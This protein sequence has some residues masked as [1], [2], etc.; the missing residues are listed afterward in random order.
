VRKVKTYTEEYVLINGIY[1]YFLHY[2]SSQKEVVIYLHG[3]PGE[4][5]ANYAHVLSPHYDFCNV[6]FYDQRGSVRYSNTVIMKHTPFPG[7]LIIL[8]IIIEH[9]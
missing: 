1:Q 8:S 9:K 7:Y 3:G 5:S 4:S 6:V 2:P